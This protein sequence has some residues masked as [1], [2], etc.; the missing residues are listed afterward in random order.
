M[1]VYVRRCNGDFV[2]LEAAIYTRKL[3]LFSVKTIYTN[4][5]ITKSVLWNGFAAWVPNIRMLFDAENKRI[6]VR[7]IK[8]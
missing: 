2:A 4:Y 1:N 5:V 7:N 6:Y 8:F 3:R